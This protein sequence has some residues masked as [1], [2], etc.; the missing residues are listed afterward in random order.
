MHKRNWDDLRYVLAVADLGSVSRAARHLG[1]NHA[2]VLRRV[3]EFES[4]HGTQIFEKTTRGYQVLADKRDVIASAREAQAAILAVE[5]MIEGRPARLQGKTRVTSTDTL[6]QSVLPEIVTGLQARSG[7]LV[8]ELLCTNAHVDLARLNIDV[9]VRPAPE[10]SP[11]LVGVKAAELGFG[12]YSGVAKPEGWLELTGPLARSVAAT[13]MAQAIDP[14]TIR[15]S[16]DS[17]M[18]LREMVAIGQSQTLLPCVLGDADARLRR[19]DGILP[20]MS[21]PVWVAS[22]ADVARAPR[23]RSVVSALAEALDARRGALLGVLT[24]G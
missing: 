12:V 10:L 17:F 19:H 7:D 5:E 6:C 24:S 11:D 13:W 15:G 9:T 1:V 16:S 21:V 20:E 14:A 2:T 4:S 22:H 18:I 3:A 23:V 8:I